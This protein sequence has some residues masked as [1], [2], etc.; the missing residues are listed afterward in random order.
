M[1]YWYW[2]WSVL[3]INV[4]VG[5]ASLSESSKLP[6]MRKKAFLYSSFELIAYICQ[7]CICKMSKSF[8]HNLTVLNHSFIEM[9]VKYVL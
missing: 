4:S 5:A 6:K 9:Y 3:S 8:A 7:F 1:R 2:Q